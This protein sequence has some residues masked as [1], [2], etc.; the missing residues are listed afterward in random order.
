MSATER[1]QHE[2]AAMELV[3]QALG[4]MVV[5]LAGEDGDQIKNPPGSNCAEE[6]SNEVFAIRDFCWCD[7]GRHPWALDADGEEDHPTCPPNF[8]HFASGLTGEWYKYLG[9]STHFSQDVGL[10]E[11]ML[12]LADCAASLG[13]RSPVSSALPT[14]ADRARWAQQKREVAQP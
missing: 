9:R 3:C 6:F 1:N 2:S 10:A 12:V 4:D 8:E 7:G 13:L 14:E 11:A 5:G